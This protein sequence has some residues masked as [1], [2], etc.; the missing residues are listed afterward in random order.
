MIWSQD[1]YHA[2]LQANDRLSIPFTV[3]YQFGKKPSLSI[4]NGSENITMRFIKRTLDTLYFEFPEVAGQLVFSSKD[5]RGY[6]LNSNATVPKKTPMV[7][8]TST[9]SGIRLDQSLNDS[10]KDYSGTYDVK[11]SSGETIEPAIGLFKQEK[12]VLSG[13]FRTET[14]DYRFLEGGVVDLKLSLS[15]F[16]GVHAYLFEATEVDGA[17]KG[18]FYSASGYHAGWVGTLNPSATLKSAYDI[19]RPVQEKGNLDVV[20]YKTFKKA[21]NINPK[22]LKGS[23]TVIQILGTWCPNCLDEVKYLSQL[24]QN[25]EF[26]GVQFLGIAFEYG[27]TKKEQYKRITRYKKNLKLPYPIY[28]GGS[29]SKKEASMVF[30]QLNGIYSF[31]TTLFINKLGQITTVHSGFDGP[32]T[33]LFYDVYKNNTEELLRQLLREK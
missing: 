30:S 14:G 16:D 2:E 21:I 32:G 27:N 22:S 9:K 23:V 3:K 5:Q 25:A 29:A 33:G 12:G 18:D 10:G 24:A 26:K 19:S 20:V 8:Y 17:L 31:P 6:W 4:I 7:F 1:L 13:T 15:C 11:F 28:L